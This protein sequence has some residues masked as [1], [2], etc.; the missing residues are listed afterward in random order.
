MT[1]AE[2]PL[3]QMKESV[4]AEAS[5]AFAFRYWTNVQNM[6]ADPGIERVETDGPYRRGMR[7]TT[8]L[9]GGGTTDWV[10]ADVE[11]DRRV[12]IDMVLGDATLRFEIRFEARADGGSLLTQTVSLFGLGA[13][14]HL[15]DV[16]TGFAT[17]L[18]DG[19]RSVRDR[20][21]EAARRGSP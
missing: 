2:P 20:I 6:T 1:D 19:M 12:V 13:A 16:A 14:R 10:V 7:G 21:D 5:P 11:V 15:D 17:S 18:S 3:W 9:A 8:H 4:E